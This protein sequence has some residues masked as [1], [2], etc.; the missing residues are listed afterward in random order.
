MEKRCLLALDKMPGISSE[1][2]K[3]LIDHGNKSC[4]SLGTPSFPAQVTLWMRAGSAPTFQTFQILFLAFWRAHSLMLEENQHIS[5]CCFPD[6]D[7]ALF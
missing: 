4:Q 7:F 6:P 3:P 2:L 5:C 1:V